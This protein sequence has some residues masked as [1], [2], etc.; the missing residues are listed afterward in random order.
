MSINPINMKLYLLLTKTMHT[1]AE[2][3]EKM[4][5]FNVIC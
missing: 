2:N 5:D 1:Q 4:W 3:Y